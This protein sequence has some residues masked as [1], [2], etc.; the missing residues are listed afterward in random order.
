MEAPHPFFA[1]T[2][3][4]GPN[5]QA[6]VVGIA[7]YIMRLCCSAPQIVLNGLWGWTHANWPQTKSAAELA[8]CIHEKQKIQK[9]IDIF[10]NHR[11]HA[12]IVKA[13]AR[14]PAALKRL[15]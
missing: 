9:V 7:Q 12:Q 8:I 15:L 13:E 10:R 14:Y 4:S 3:E 6:L 11:Y 5:H 1:S 2:R